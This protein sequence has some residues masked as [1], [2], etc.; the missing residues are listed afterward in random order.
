VIP[1]VAHFIWFGSDLP[2]VHAVALRSAARRAGLGHIV[3][4][5]DSDLSGRPVWRDLRATPGFESRR[6]DPAA[7]FRAAGVDAAELLELYGRLVQPAARANVLRAAILAA[8]GGVYLDTDT[9]TVASL[10][11]L[12]DAQAFCG[13][14]RVV[15]PAAIVQGRALWPKVRAY[16][17]TAVREVVRWFPDG[18][19]RFRRIEHRYPVAP[20]N[21]VLACEPGHPFV[22]QLLDGMLRM[23]RERQTVRYALGTHLLEQVIEAGP[24]PGLRVHPPEVFYPLGPEISEHW[25]RMRDHVDLQS[26]LTPATRVVHWYA[27]VRTKRI[28]PRIDPQYVR[29]NQQRQLLSA[30][31]APYA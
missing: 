22:M 27:S 6:V 9:V 28:V 25:F 13:V 12:C 17:M 14:E 18:Y 8:E 30:L 23:P 21:A 7:T 31:L 5:H 4:H 2:W 26:A 16:G 29:Q 11:P 1:A 19:R 24:Q 3:L 20:N 10:A 15:F